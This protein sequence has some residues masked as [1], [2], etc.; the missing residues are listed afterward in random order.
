LANPACTACLQTQA[1]VT[2]PITTTTTTTTTLANQISATLQGALLNAGI[3]TEMT[4]NTSAAGGMGSSFNTASLTGNTIAET[5]TNA[6][7]GGAV[8]M[9]F[10][11]NGGGIL[12]ANQNTGANAVQQNSMTFTS[13]GNG[14]VLSG[15]SPTS[16]PV[17]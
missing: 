5:P 2:N 16:T 12:Q 7:V 4:T 13:V 14:G 1:N 10:S 3:L 15:L 9:S 6:S 17:H 8:S 11:M